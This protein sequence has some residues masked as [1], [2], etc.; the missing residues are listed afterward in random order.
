MERIKVQ[1]DDSEFSA[2]VR[3]AEQE[4]RSVPDQARLAVRDH[5]QRNGWLDAESSKKTVA[6]GGH[7]NT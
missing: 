2:L 5:L 4:L 3:L 6:I 1:L 7:A